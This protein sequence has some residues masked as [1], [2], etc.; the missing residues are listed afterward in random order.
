MYQAF[1]AP[2]NIYGPNVFH[3]FVHELGG[4]KS[5]SRFLG[6]TERTVWRWLSEGNVP[7]AAVLA[8]YWET[9]YGRSQIFTDQVNEIRELY[10]R[11]CLLQEQYTRAKDIV[12]GLRKLQTGGANEPIFEELE[13]NVVVTQNNFEA[14]SLSAIALAIQIDGI[15]TP[16]QD[17]LRAEKTEAIRLVVERARAAVATRNRPRKARA[18]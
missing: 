14:G 5:V 7:R 9:Q 16:S 6:V 1:H 12:A 4:P 17:E 18:A 3:A 2:R 15:K 8:L 11:V 13:G 10:R